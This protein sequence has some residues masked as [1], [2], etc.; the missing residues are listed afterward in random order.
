MRVMFT[1]NYN[2]KIDIGNIMKH[3]TKL[4]AKA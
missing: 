3:Y 4:P 2:L 1:G